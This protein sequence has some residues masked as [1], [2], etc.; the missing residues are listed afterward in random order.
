M[1]YKILQKD[2][3]SKSLKQVVIENRELTKNDVDFI[4][5][6]T[7]EYVE[8]PYKLK[9]MFEA[10][11]LFMN[12]LEMESKIAILV[13]SDTDGFTSSALMYLF[14]INECG[15][16]KDKIEIIHHTKKMHGLSDEEVFKKIK[17]SDI[18]FLIIPDAATNDIAE[19]KELMK[20]GKR[21]LVLDHHQ[22]NDENQSTIFYDQ[23]KGLI[24]VI[25][26]NQLD[27]YSTD[28]SGVGVTYKFLNAL[29]E[30]E[31][32]HYMDLVAIGNVADSM[33]L[34]GY[35]IRYVV[36]KGLK[37]INN[38]L[39]KEFMIDSKL[40]GSLTPTDVSFNI[41]NKINAVIRYGSVEEKTN[42]FRALIEE[43]E[44][45]EYTPR[46][47][48]T[49]PNPTTEIQTLQ[50]AMVRLS[51]SIKQKQDNAKK[52]CVE[53]C[54]EFI[55]E[56]NLN[57][58]KVI[59]VIDEDGSLI[60]RKITGLIAM[61]LVDTYKKSVILL[62][63]TKEK[64]TGSIRGYGIESFKDIL[65]KTEIVEVIGHN[66]SAGIFVETKDIPRLIK[67]INR[68]F[69]DVEITPPCTLVDCEINLDT[70]RQKEMQ[71]IVD[72][73]PIWHQHCNS[74]KFL[75][76]DLVIDSKKVRNPYTTLL[77]FDVNGIEIQKPFCSKVFKENFLHEKEVKF[78]KPILKM[79]LIVE[80]GYDEY[81]RKPCLIIV[82]A[83]SEI[84]KE[85]KKNNNDKIPF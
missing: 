7:N 1:D 80:I 64:Y 29:T 61:Q 33:E 41:S 58:N 9:N 68:V 40:E 39:I 6:P 53:K 74:P 23:N 4:L 15:Y 60:D 24:G 18:N 45:I 54:K 52:K 72:M 17:N 83:E 82:N 19:L 50:K 85:N 25:V 63:K 21:I 51:K 67:R 62:S 14:L 26:N 66:N 3:F 59:V 79:N 36:N 30:D 28:F 48:K 20:I 12:E 78:G 73:K 55:Q 10:T 31:L 70:I 65:E 44:E 37:N 57:D 38:E 27:E 13:D 43:K 8:N 5:N 76:K 32:V 35:E 49:N 22:M 11:K 42:L 47:S 81:K 2:I 84:V 77:V 34:N 56:N 46:K 75:I 69:E 16:P 71:E